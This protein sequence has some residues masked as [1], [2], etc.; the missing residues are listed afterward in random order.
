M[1]IAQ[2]A[3]LKPEAPRLSANRQHTLNAPIDCEGVGVHSGTKVRMHIMPA[4]TNTGIVFIRTDLVNGARRVEA[5]WDRVVD[6]K[7]CT[8]IGND[9]GTRVATIEHLMAALAAY[10]IDNAVVEIDGAEVPVMDGSSHDFV[11]YLNIA[12]VRAQ[13]A[14]RRIIEILS[15]LTVGDK[16][17]NAS[18][19]PAPVSRY[20]VSIA[21]DRAPIG[22]QSFDLV[23]TPD[24]FRT[25]V[26]RARTFGFYE[27][28]A[29]LRSQGL[30]QGGSLENAVVIKD[31]SVLNEDGLRYADEFARH[32]LLDAVGDIAL[33][34]Y[35]I[36]GHFTGVC[37]GHDL[38]NRLLHALWAQPDAW[39]IVNA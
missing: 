6:T 39:R 36:R 31:G 7:L 13:K 2:G 9:H 32:K 30:A 29:Y 3:L 26:S 24:A 1:Q 14:Q 25:E 19:T 34:G 16:N 23:L 8:V 37:T 38:N 5:K 33:A 15:P 27:D 12:G 18:L 17:K 4:D 20:S 35:P 11:E 28:V 22:Q 10:G 21:F